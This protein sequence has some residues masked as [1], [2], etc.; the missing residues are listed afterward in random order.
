MVAGYA[1]S[2]TD[3]E[4]ELTKNKLLKGNTRAYESLGAKLGILREISKYEK[5]V[6]YLEDGQ[7]E[8]VGMSLD[9]YKQIISEYMNEE[10]LIYLVVGDKASQLEEV[11]KL[12]KPV[13]ELD[14][15]GNKI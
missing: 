1:D 6:T 15:Y 12:G 11:K 8:L 9:D 7:N 13:T 3:N 10:E 2:F 4:V 14:I 5:P